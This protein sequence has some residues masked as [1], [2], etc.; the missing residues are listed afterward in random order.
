MKTSAF[1]IVVLF[2]AA[3]LA[4]A[5]WVLVQK[6]ST[7]G[8]EAEVT[9]KIKG[10]QA[11]VNMGEK[12]SVIVGAEGMTM[13]MHEQK[14]VMKRDLATI[15]AAVEKMGKGSAGQQAAKPVATGQK[16]KVGEWDTEIFTW[17][18]Q[19]GKGRFWVAKDF[20]KYAEISAFSDK[21]GKIVGG[22]M[23]ALS[24]QAADFEGMVVKSEVTMM[25]KSVSSN[26]V[27][28]K[29]ETVAA[30]EFVPPTGYT[31]MKMPGAPR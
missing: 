21:L 16:E 2:L 26:L 19:M 3:T 8:K 30:E 14:M 9:T 6:T 22:A 1:S 29:E 24:P 15:K 25:G 28:A 4:Q 7:E 18:G 17:E 12:M 27:S 20:P 13:I 5:D 10:D 11:R 23:S 31:E